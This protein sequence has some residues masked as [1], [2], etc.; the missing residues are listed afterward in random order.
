MES[1]APAAAGVD[2]QERGTVVRPDPQRADVFDLMPEHDPLGT[3]RIGRRED[4]RHQT[5]RRIDEI[6]AEIRIDEIVVRIHLAELDEPAG[7]QFLIEPVFRDLRERRLPRGRLEFIVKLK[8]VDPSGRE[9]AAEEMFAV[10]EEL[11]PVPPAERRRVGVEQQI[12][13]PEG[14][15]PVPR[16]LPAAGDGEHVA[17]VNAF[18]R[19]GLDRFR[20]GGLEEFRQPGRGG[21]G[22]GQTR[23]GL[24][25]NR[26][27]DG[28]CGDRGRPS[29][30][31]LCPTSSHV[32]PPSSR[33]RTRLPRVGIGDRDGRLDDC[34]AGRHILPA[35]AV[36]LGRHVTR[37]AP[38]RGGR[39]RNR[40]SGRRTSTGF[41]R[42]SCGSRLRSGRVFASPG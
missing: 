34:P 18:Q 16:P 20:L 11:A 39:S 38:H 17:G 24:R 40:G 32:R 30:C 23:R 42:R 4:G 6:R 22:V 3:I 13:V 25:A 21:R 35:A 12:K 15:D 29:E 37:P 27:A 1:K 5:E 10:N 14:R 41:R 2:A 26:P 9:G 7:R 31:R 33:S 8:I 28:E 36:S 19:V